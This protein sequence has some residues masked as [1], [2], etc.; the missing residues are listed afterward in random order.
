[1]FDQKNGTRAR[2]SSSPIRSWNCGTSKTGLQE[3]GIDADEGGLQQMQCQDGDLGVLAVWAGGVAVLADFSNRILVTCLF[4]L[5]RWAYSAVPVR[6][7]CGDAVE[8]V[9]VSA[10][11]RRA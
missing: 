7:P 3:K 4:P 1:M 8:P 5:L 10:G 9:R 6:Q 2:C 11:G